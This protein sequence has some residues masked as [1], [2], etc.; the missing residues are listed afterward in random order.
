MPMFLHR[1]LMNESTMIIHSLACLLL[2]TSQ[3]IRESALT[4][5]HARMSPL[6]KL[7]KCRQSLIQTIHRIILYC[8]V[9]LEHASHGVEHCSLAVDITKLCPGHSGTLFLHCELPCSTFQLMVVSLQR[10]ARPL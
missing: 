1:H 8:V 2:I 5:S 4:C 6:Q 7:C 10:N 3:K 9:L